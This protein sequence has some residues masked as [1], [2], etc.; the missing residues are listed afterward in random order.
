MSEGERTRIRR[1]KLYREGKCASCLSQ[2]DGWQRDCSACRDAAASLRAVKLVEGKCPR[3]GNASGKFRFCLE[4][5]LR[6][7]ERARTRYRRM[8]AA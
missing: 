7:A 2:R 1:A 6:D 8:E 5:R 4:C 3:D